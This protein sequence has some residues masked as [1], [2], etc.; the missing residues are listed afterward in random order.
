MKN[1]IKKISLIIAVI[2][3]IGASF[4][5]AKPL[6]VLALAVIYAP[7]WNNIS[8]LVSNIIIMAIIVY[9]VYKYIIYII[10]LLQNKKKLKPIILIGLAILII[11]LAILVTTYSA[12]FTSNILVPFLYIV[13][14]ITAP[15]IL[16]GMIILGTHQNRKK[17]I[18][19][20][21]ITIIITIIIY[22]ITYPYLAQTAKNIIGGIENFIV[23]KE[24]KNSNQSMEYNL[25]YLENYKDK[26]ETEGYLDKYDI[27]KIL[28]IVD[29]RTDNI[30]VHYI[31]G[32]EETQYNNVDNQL[33][34]EL[35]SKLESNSYKFSYTHKDGKTDIYIENYINE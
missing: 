23:S 16:I 15:I 19:Y 5:Y 35:G 3:V 18:I 20:T 31:D 34:D 28:T 25:I 21:I 32:E 2:I 24:S 30:I 27:Q 4:V 12:T 29:S 26:M 17:K 10:Q 7:K 8:V 14:I 22:L 6:Y 13:C 33:S 11:V 1:I 9:I